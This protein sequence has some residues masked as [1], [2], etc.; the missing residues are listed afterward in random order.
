MWAGWWNTNGSESTCVSHVTKILLDTGIKPN[1]LKLIGDFHEM[2][3]SLDQA[4]EKRLRFFFFFSGGGLGVGSHINIPVR[5][6]QA[7]KKKSVGKGINF[8]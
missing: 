1:S 7:L 6:S 4:L 3:W 8:Y 2:Q 5:M